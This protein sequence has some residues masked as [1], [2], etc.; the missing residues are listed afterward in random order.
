MFCLHVSIRATCMPGAGG[1]QK[2]ALDPFKPQLWL[3]VSH[4]GS[5]NRTQALCKYKCF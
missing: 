2:R 4:V 5:G 1:V 3:V